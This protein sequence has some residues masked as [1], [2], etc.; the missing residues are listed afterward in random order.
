MTLKRICSIIETE[1]SKERKEPKMART[2]WSIYKS[3]NETLRGGWCNCPVCEQVS[4]TLSAISR[5][6][7]SRFDKAAEMAAAI[8][9]FNGGKISSKDFTTYC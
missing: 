3:H 8:K 1:K 4:G 5:R 9:S 7:G 6:E 2:K